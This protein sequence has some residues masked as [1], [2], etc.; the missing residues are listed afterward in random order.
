MAVHL[1]PNQIEEMFKKYKESGD[2]DDYGRNL[3]GQ[4][5]TI[6]LVKYRKKKIK[7]LLEK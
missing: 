3:E 7:F 6:K 5:D 2:I 4:F 1:N